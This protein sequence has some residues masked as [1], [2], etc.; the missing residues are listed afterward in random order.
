MNSIKAQ[1]EEKIREYSNEEYLDGYI[2]NE[3][4]TNDGNADIFLKID[5]KNELFDSKTVG[6]QIDL[7]KDIYNY[8]ENKSSM[9]KS[10]I[11]L[12]LKIVSMELNVHDIE[13]VKH[14][15]NEHY[16]IELY[17]AQR[18]YRRYKAK[19]VKHIFVGILFIICYALIV[20]NT[21]S[22]FFSEIFG[23]L[24]SFSLWHAI[25]TYLVNMKDIKYKREEITQK[26]LMNVSLNNGRH[27]FFKKNDDQL[28]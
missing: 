28:N 10:D 3:F 25:E 26:L 27:K 16:A 5:N 1:V 24:F 2:K 6:N 7:K 11:Q 20:L 21:E 9:L 18:K 13:Q 12:Q 19:A 14:I 8:I 15:I 17:K 22:K 4:L 23:F